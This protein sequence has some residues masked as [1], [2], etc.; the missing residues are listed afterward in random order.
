MRRMLRL[1]ALVLGTMTI[2]GIVASPAGAATTANVTP[3]PVPV[4]PGEDTALITIDYDFGKPTTA[5]FIDI[6][7]KPQSDPTFDYIKD[8]DRGSANAFNGSSDGAGSQEM[9]IPVGDNFG[10]RFFG[11][12]LDKW[13]CYPADRA[14]PEGFVRA[15]TCWVRVTQNVVG[16][17]DDAV[18]VEFTFAEG[19]AEIPEAPMVI[20]PV[21]A[22][23]G[24]V[25]AFLLVNRRRAAA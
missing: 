9:E 19:G 5:V 20:L 6:C 21:V 7:K 16:N 22:G 23:A 11:D 3:N 13:G 14:T 17:S 24:L 25:G 15:E 8:C 1:A 12:E 10:S 2:L 4:A 18:S